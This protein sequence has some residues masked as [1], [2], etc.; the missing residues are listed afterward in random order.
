MNNILKMH[1]TLAKI[2]S[3]VTMV[4]MLMKTLMEFNIYL[5]NG[6]KVSFYRFVLRKFCFNFYFQFLGA[7]GIPQASPTRDSHRGS[8]MTMDDN[9]GR[10]SPGMTDNCQSRNMF[11]LQEAEEVKRIF[12]NSNR[13]IFKSNIYFRLV[14][15]Y[16]NHLLLDT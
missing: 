1:L 13:N 4:M 7:V 12:K 8:P 15:Y 10:Q 14:N 16:N 5:M 9:K 11:S 6:T 2:F 3:L